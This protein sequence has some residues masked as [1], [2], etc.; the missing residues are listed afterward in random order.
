MGTDFL[1]TIAFTISTW[2]LLVLLNI[3][4]T[5]QLNALEDLLPTTKHRQTKHPQ[6]SKSPF[7]QNQLRNKVKSFRKRHQMSGVRFS[8]MCG[9]SQATF[10]SFKNGKTTL[11]RATVEKITRTMSGYE[12]R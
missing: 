5:N 11:Q 6:P 10:F 8:E 12:K 2:I 4:T 3:K 7:S 9:I 1:I